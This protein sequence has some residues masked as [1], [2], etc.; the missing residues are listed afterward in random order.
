[1]TK[2]QPSGRKYPIDALPFEAFHD[3]SWHRIKDVRIK[4]GNVTVQFEHL[5]SGT[6]EIV[7]TH[8]LRLRS[9]K[10]TPSDCR[11]FLQPGMDI[12]VFSAY[13]NATISDEE[14]VK[15]AWHNAKIISIERRP[16]DYRCTCMYS[17]SIYSSGDQLGKRKRTVEN[18]IQEVTIDNIAILQKLNRKPYEDGGDHRDSSEDCCY[19]QKS[20]LSV[21]TFFSEVAWLV[22]LSI[23]KKTDFHIRSNGEKIVYLFLNSDQGAE[24]QDSFS[25]DSHHVKAI[26]FHRDYGKLQLKI[27]T[28]V[29]V[30][31]ERMF[32]PPKIN[33][34][35]LTH[36]LYELSELRRSTRRKAPPDRFVGCS[37]SNGKRHSKKSSRNQ[38]SKIEIISSSS[39]EYVSEHTNCLEEEVMGKM[40]SQDE[41]SERVC[42]TQRKIQL[43]KRNNCFNSMK[44]ESSSLSSGNAGKFK[45]AENHKKVSCSHERKLE[46]GGLC[47]DD[48]HSI[49]LQKLSKK[50][51]RNQDTRYIKTSKVSSGCPPLDKSKWLLV[52]VQGPNELHHNEVLRTCTEN[53]GKNSSKHQSSFSIETYKDIH[54]NFP[55]GKGHSSYKVK[56]NCSHKKLKSGKV[57]SVDWLMQNGSDQKLQ[58]GKGS[59]KA[60]KNSYLLSLR[61][62]RDEG[63][64][65]RYRF[66]TTGEYKQMVERCMK[67]IE[68][69]IVRKQ[70]LVVAQWEAKQA[71]NNV[72]SMLRFNWPSDIDDRVEITEHEDL[73]K[74]MENALTAL[75]ST[76]C[77]E[78][79]MELMDA[80][81]KSS[82]KG[83][84]QSCQHEY[85]MNEEVGIICSL[86]N[87]VI[88][89]M[90]YVLPRFLHSYGWVR[91]ERQC[92]IDEMEW[93]ATYNFG[94]DPLGR[95]IPS[96]EM[97]TL[98]EL[99][100]VWSLIPKLKL[101]LHDHQRKAFEFLWKNIAGSLNPVDMELESKKWGGCVISHPPGA[102]KTLLV[103]SFLE[104]Y[105][106]LFPQRRPLILAPNTTLYAWYQEF[107][108]WEISFPIYQ[109]HALKSFHK[110]RK[111]MPE[112]QT[113]TMSRDGT[114]L[115]FADCLE[116]F[117][118]WHEHPSVLL[119]SYPTFFAMIRS[120]ARLEHRRRLGEVL[121]KS[122]GILILDEGHNPR[123]TRSKLRK[124]LMEMKTDLRILLSGTLFQNNFEEY[125]NTL[126]LARPRF[127]DEVAAELKIRNIKQGKRATSIH[128]EMKA[129]KYFVEKIARRINS[130]VEKERNKGLEIL[131]KI[132]NG[133]IDVYNGI[134]LD[135][136]PGLQ[137][138]TLLMKPTDIQQKILSRLQ[139]SVPQKGYLLE[140]ELLITFAS[141]HP[142]LIKTISCVGKYFSKD[143]LDGLEAHKFDVWKGMKVK[144]VIDLVRQCIVKKEKLLIFCHNIPPI[145]LFVELLEMFLGWKKNREVLVL[146]GDLDL[147][148]RARVMDK[149]K[150]YGGSSQLLLASTGACAEGISLTAASRVVMLDSEWNPSK[151]KQAIA[152]AFRP[153]QE[154]VVYVYQL[155]AS[156]TIEE[157]KYDRNEMKERQSRMIFTGNCFADSSCRQTVNIDDDVLR[158][159]VEED[160]TKAFNMIMK[161][162]KF[163]KSQGNQGLD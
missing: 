27:E 110:Q 6:W 30:V 13:P 55:S 54:M 96:R 38:P 65:Y 78:A 46:D 45:P 33:E 31:R 69:E 47:K 149:F 12:C 24:N 82:Q 143:E 146:Q 3:G 9:R 11:C 128:R 142:W 14:N 76:E 120:D 160:Q 115:H 74:E 94:L 23:F 156:G 111:V 138:Y 84:R 56:N 114:I 67:N 1:M 92:S 35:D 154:R 97:S 121:R 116:K 75:P 10:A 99:D 28:F 42:P 108:K 151:T 106:S 93:T 72:N 80:T 7:A 113:N 58:K 140:V 34:M 158:E 20:K 135:K 81:A 16:H 40:I 145:N 86:C 147:I 79:S 64:R 150:E 52:E 25:L 112:S 100:S 136:L 63:R 124:A 22:V 15:P 101:K 29:P 159:I 127:I 26:G 77:Q 105:L 144:F 71:V 133:F 4:N 57:S 36:D 8:D 32:V 130:S 19:V 125:F 85:K 62:S 163:S 39:D 137:C 141:I 17:V 139:Q 48:S 2:K 134:T 61:K 132:T 148:E 60:S 123:S 131:K 37:F 49:H 89:E 68:F 44:Q 103:L 122:P 43:K 5:G 152:R 88:T 83:G 18:S 102:G 50:N 53:I 161:H 109:I 104:S 90:R 21:G 157:G 59:S 98:E 162:E 51:C 155:L 41:S 73:W 117:K 119:M 129:R 118:K 91:G 70:P 153:G 95:A 87:S 126:C 107:E 66:F